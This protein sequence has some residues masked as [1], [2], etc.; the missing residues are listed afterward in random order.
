M[1]PERTILVTGATDGIGRRLARQLAAPGVHLLLHG[2][3]VERGQ[4]AVAEANAAGAQ[5]TLF[6]ADF[7]SLA[8]VRAMAEAVAAVHP[9]LDILVNNAGVA[10]PGGSRRES[11]DGFE[12]HLAVNYLAP[13]LLTHLLRRPLAASAGSRIVNVVSAAQRRLDL[14]DLMFERRY[15]GYEA[16]GRSKL[17]LVMLTL[18]LA[19]RWRADAIA[20]ACLH[21][22]SHLDT[23]T[24]RRAGI[25]PAGS[26]DDGAGAVQTLVEADAQTING[27][28]F[29][30]RR[31]ARAH[32][33]AYDDA[34]R[35]ALRQ[36]SLAPSG[37]SE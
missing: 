1:S 5:A 14:D 20:A 4:A 10:E 36:R 27:R 32:A 30:V 16:Y 9:H 31:E 29:E 2:R 12:W 33:Q 7:A 3:D 34:A 26:A 23:A 28:Y 18:D 37:L 22:G 21:P 17:A 24:V 15:E 8:S 13:F 6:R 19:E 25:R 11:E 35:R